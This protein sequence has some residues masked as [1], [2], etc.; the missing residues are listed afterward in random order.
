MV[1][2]LVGIKPILAKLLTSSMRGFHMSKCSWL[3]A[4][5]IELVFWWLRRY[6]VRFISAN[7]NAKFWLTVTR[8]TISSTDDGNDIV[9]NYNRLFTSIDFIKNWIYGNRCSTAACKPCRIFHDHFRGHHHQLD[10]KVKRDKQPLLN[11]SPL[12]IHVW[13][14]EI[15]ENSRW[16]L[17]YLKSLKTIIGFYCD[18]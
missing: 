17:W 9:S 13:I 8:L 1:F 10:K 4:I 6:E 12:P 16:P 11:W 14:F 3:P 2:V 5:T 15:F 18:Y 7:H